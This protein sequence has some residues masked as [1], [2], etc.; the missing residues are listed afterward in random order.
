M[1]KKEERKVKKA[2]RKNKRAEKKENRQQKSKVIKGKLKNKWGSKYKDIKNQSVLGYKSI[3]SRVRSNIRLEILFL[4]GVSLIVAS[5]IGWS[6]K[7]IAIDAGIGE[8]TYTRYENSRQDLQNRLVDAIREITNIENMSLDIYIDTEELREIIAYQPIEEGIEELRYFLVNSYRVSNTQYGEYYDFATEDISLEKSRQFYRELDELLNEGKWNQEIVTSMVMDFLNK[9]VGF[10]IEDL[11]I[12]RVQQIIYNVDENDRGVMD[13]QTYILDSQGNTFYEDSFVQRVDI[14]KAIQRSSE[15]SYD[16]NSVTSIY[17]VI[18]N[19]EIHYLFNESTLEGEREIFY[20]STPTVLAWLIGVMVFVFLIF[21]FTKT[22]IRYIEYISHCL[23]E[24]SKGDLNYQ[25][26]VVGQDELAKVAADVAYMEEQIKTQ[27]EAQKQAEKTKNEL[28]TN[29]AHDLRTPLTSIIGY[30]GLIKEKRYENEE[31]YEKYL[32]IAYNKSEKLKELIEDLFEYTK[33]TNQ[34]VNLKKQDISIANLINQLVE[35]LMPLAEDKE[36]TI[37]TSVDAG[38]TKVKV[39]VTK[40][41]RVFENLIENAIK[42]TEPK[43]IIHMG[44]QETSEYLFISIRNKCNNLSEEDVD[45]LF[46]RFYRSD[47]SRNSSTGGSGLG[48]AIS[49]NIVNLHGGEIWAQLQG[50]IVSFNVKL[51]N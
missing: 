43:S 3:D 13:T 6:T 46:D 51:K 34:S 29:V 49:K 27:I 28:I 24:I 20:T 14:V 18:I 16:D 23:G 50:N 12:Q 25:I 47:A 1:S 17:P 21:R 48:L 40:M 4:V 11:K 19:G 35:E 33:L 30:I 2:E 15:S 32:E 7:N 9:E 38:D 41:T 37:D 8:R 44:I 39:D 22:K 45:R 42:Y 36:V 10:T 31:E 26:E 5:A